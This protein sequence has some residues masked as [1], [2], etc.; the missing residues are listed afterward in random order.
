MSFRFSLTSL[1]KNFTFPVSNNFLNFNLP[2]LS[3]GSLISTKYKLLNKSNY[4]VSKQFVDM[5]DLESKIE[6]NRSIINY[7]PYYRTNI[8]KKFNNDFK[9]FNYDQNENIN[10]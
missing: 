9:K 3:S 8:F 1:F 7:S 5:E 2:T 4:R 10:Y 6:D